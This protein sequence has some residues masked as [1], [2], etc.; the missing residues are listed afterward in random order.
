MDARSHRYSLTSTES[1][2][3]TRR[4]LTGAPTACITS[5]RIGGYPNGIHPSDAA[6]AMPP[7]MLPKPRAMAQGPRIHPGTREV[8]SAGEAQR[9]ASC[10]RH[11]AA[12]KAPG[13][14]WLCGLEPVRI[15]PL[16]GAPVAHAGIRH[17]CPIGKR[18]LGI[19]PEAPAYL[20]HA[21]SSVS[22]SRHSMR[23]TSCTT[24]TPTCPARSPTVAIG[25]VMRSGSLPVCPVVLAD[26][27]ARTRPAPPDRGGRT[28]VVHGAPA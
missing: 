17:L 12:A 5:P 23:S 28:T 8:P 24:T 25:S 26:A 22:A 6:A 4:A 9:S 27:S 21:D 1:P 13:C 7:R 20:R 19:L 14:S 15:G 11:S 3:R 16:A 2:N 10:R 18:E